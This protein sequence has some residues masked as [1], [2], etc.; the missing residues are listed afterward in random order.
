MKKSLIIIF[1][2]ISVVLHATNYYVKKSGNNNN[3]GLTNLQAWATLEKVN[4]SSFWAGDTIFFNRGDKWREQLT[5]PSSGN[6]RANITFSAYGVGAKPIIMGS[7]LVVNWKDI[8]SN[9]W[10][11]PLSVKPNA[12]YFNGV[13]G[14]LVVSPGDVIGTHKWFYDTGSEL[15]YIYSASD[16]N[17]AFVTPGIEACVRDYCILASPKKDYITYEYLELMHGRI[18]GLYHLENFT[19]VTADS[20]VVHN[21][22]E[23]FTQAVTY[24]GLKMEG[25]SYVTIRNCVAYEN[26]W[27]G[28]S[29]QSWSGSSGAK[30]NWLVENCKSYNNAHQ[31]FN[32]NTGTVA[33]SNVI[34]R[35]NESYGAPQDNG[36]F[37][38]SGSDNKVMSNVY[39]YYNLFYDNISTG[40]LIGNIGQEAYMSSIYVY[41]NTTIRNGT[42]GIGRGIAVHATHTTVKNNIIAN[43]EVLGSSVVEFEV[44][45]SS[46]ISDYNL[47]Y[48]ALHN[49]SS[50]IEW[51]SSAMTYSN[52]KSTTG[53]ESHGVSAAPS[54][55]SSSNFHIQFNSPCINAGIRVGLTTDLDGNTSKDPPSIGAYEYY[56]SVLLGNLPPVVTISNPRKGNKYENPATITIDAI[57]SDPD[58]SINKVEFYSG[59]IKLFELT[60]A[61]YSYTWKDVHA[62]TYIITATATDNFDATTTSSPVEFVVGAD[63]NYNADSKIINLYPNPNDGHFSIEFINLLQNEKSEIL[64]TNFAGK[65]VFSSPVSKEETLKHIDLSCIKSGIYILMIIG[66]EILVTKKFIIK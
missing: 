61:P 26:G 31:G 58:G 55:Y 38:F 48:N 39:V 57:A 46:N 25:G 49:S 65:R 18:H 33:V 4:G 51:E 13:V 59:L 28:I 7:D 63:I 41:N 16:P 50:I 15:L 11:S 34:V 21:N 62:G 36:L 9:K 8:G 3:T 60:S 22:G 12:I 10:A 66:K 23:A 37:I 6:S 56:L 32:I 1:L 64:I 43:N 2:L 42:M 5:V 54:F 52:F 14:T 29:V 27:N 53:Q 45:G 17:T 20:L 44:T 30:T 47:I 19:N 24:D 35:Y 40:L